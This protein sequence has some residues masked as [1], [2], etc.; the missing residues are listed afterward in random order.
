MVIQ[1][2]FEEDWDALSGYFAVSAGIKRV[3]AV[4]SG[5]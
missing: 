2:I 4:I 5:R 1:C 3:A